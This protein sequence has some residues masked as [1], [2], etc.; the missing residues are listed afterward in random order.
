LT[1]STGLS[2]GCGSPW[3]CLRVTLLRVSLLL[4]GSGP[5]AA[6]GDGSCGRKELKRPS[7]RPCRLSVWV[8]GGARVTGH[9]SGVCPQGY[10]KL[11]EDRKCLL[12]IG[13]VRAGS[14]ILMCEL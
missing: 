1:D 11:H 10:Q 4:E 12:E 9:A 13:M 5:V 3:G 14:P 2:P 6:E 7:V 8:M